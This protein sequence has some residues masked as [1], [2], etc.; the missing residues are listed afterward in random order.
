MSKF[1]VDLR[2][3]LHLRD[4]SSGYFVITIIKNALPLLILPILTRYLN[5]EEYGNVALF[6]FYFLIFNSLA[7]ISIPTVI[8]KYFYK[9]EKKNLSEIIGNSIL[10]SGVIS[11]FLVFIVFVFYSSIEI[12]VYI[13]KMW[14]LLIPIT[15]FA[16]ILFS[17]GLNV[18]R[19]SKKVFDFGVYQ[20]GNIAINIVLSILFVVVFNFNWQ[21]R[22]LA[23][24]LSFIISS[25][26][27]FYY[28]RK[29]G[30]LVFNFSSIITRKVLKVMVPLVPNSL[31][32]VVISQIGIFF[33]QYYY[34]KEL[35]GIY[36]IGFQLAFAVKILG[37]TLNLSWSPYLFEQIS[38]DKILNKLYITRMI[39][40]L[41]AIV[42]VGL[43]FVNLFSESILRLLTTPKY[44]GSAEFIPWFSIGFLFQSLYIFLF[45]I[46]IRYEKQNYISIVT[47]CGMFV[48]IILN[49]LLSNAFGYIGISYSFAITYLLIFIAMFWKVQGTM[50]LPWLRALKIWQ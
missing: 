20:V 42:F 11:L 30:Y 9:L 50:P 4:L 22:I 24:V 7:G 28:L 38:N 8:S 14:L 23:I 48:M 34:T 16:F 31:Q 13:P 2:G 3:L 6:T 32:A 49:I 25:I 47:F 37:D 43:V 27:I 45:P 5:P 36:S 39:Y 21:G 17:V 46:L 19:N 35:L 15:S 33:I 18:M 40:L 41:I 44:Y 12:F 29:N 26:A 1:K 10:I